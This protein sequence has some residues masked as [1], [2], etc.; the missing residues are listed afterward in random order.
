VRW[1]RFAA[2]TRVQSSRVLNAQPS[3][4]VRELG[5]LA[6]HTSVYGLGVILQQLAGFLLL[7]LYTNLLTPADY[8]VL[9]VTGLAVALIGIVLAGGLGQALAKFFHQENDEQN[10]RKV[11]ATLYSITAMSAIAGLVVFMPAAPWIAQI[12]LGD[13]AWAPAIML[14]IGSLSVGLISDFGFV[15]LRVVNR[16]LPYITL[17]LL[18]LLINIG[19]NI[20]ALMVF[21]LGV[22]GVLFGGLAS[23]LITGAIL[24]GLVLRQTGFGVDR[25]RLAGM[26]RY[27][28]PLIPSR[29]ASTVISYSDRFFLT[30]LS[31]LA[32]V[33]LYA[34]AQKIAAAIHLLVN[35]AFANTFEPRRFEI[36]K[37]ED[38]PEV[39][40]K[41]FEAHVFLSLL[42]AAG[43]SVVAPQIFQLMAGPE[44]RAASDFVWL[45]VACT[46]L[47]GMRMHCEFGLLY[48]GRTKGVMYVNLLVAGCQIALNFALIPTWQIWGAL[49]AQLI[50]NSLALILLHAGSRRVYPLRIRPLWLLKAVFCAVAAYF[51]ADLINAVSD[52]AVA[53]FLLRG[54]AV[55]VVYF[56]LATVLAVIPGKEVLG[57]LRAGRVNSASGGHI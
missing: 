37:R 4:S 26:L 9:E 51:C 38:G 46:L 1:A 44:F 35:S 17:S 13:A 48:S 6:R 20:S 33:G 12:A 50:C 21:D 2:L 32:A 7:P 40:A 47:Y 41:V 22:L 24:S 34:L 16:S 11:V 15:Y 45:A 30:H 31:G 53:L 18:G 52:S 54:V 27:A 3:A 29:L 57:L 49:A 39:L 28:V 8:G 43:I 19:I 55:M 5:F 14:G 42:I 56:G 10:Q 23:R 36:A 25:Q